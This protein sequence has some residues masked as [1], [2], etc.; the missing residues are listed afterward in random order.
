M[1]GEERLWLGR[2]WLLGAC[3]ISFICVVNV[4]TIQH[5]APHL[6]VIR[7]VIWE[8]SSALVTL[9]IFSI[10]AAMAFWVVR[11]RPRW[12]LVLPAHLAAVFVYSVLHVAGFIA[13]RELSYVVILDSHYK[14][15]PLA[16]EFPYEF[17]KDMMAYGLA[18]IIYW[19]AL[20]RGGYSP[21]TVEPAQPAV[22]DIRDGARLIRVPV[23]EIIAVRSAGNYVEFILGDGRRPL[24]RSSLGAALESLAR[25]GFVRT[26]K[27]WL[28]NKARVTGLTPEGS[29]DYTVELG[30]LE[31][32]LS[33]RFPEA[34]AILRG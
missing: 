30:N 29:G 27:S 22:F 9:F 16:T 20:Q 31:A 6:G 10:P 15:G 12:W 32:P 3:L 4:L 11:T 17:R 2:A 1:S 33:R 21:P 25:H 26:H 7:P 19:L 18:S 28:V 8:G 13:L 14:F 5:D 34:L 23:A 24:T